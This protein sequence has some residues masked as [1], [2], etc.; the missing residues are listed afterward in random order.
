M[1]TTIYQ[2]SLKLLQADRTRPIGI[3]CGEPLPK[4]WICIMGVAARIATTQLARIWRLKALAGR[5]R[6]LCV[7][8]ITAVGRSVHGSVEEE[9]EASI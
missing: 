7:A 5:R 3:D 6:T 1:M 8:G 2:R 9:C 4:L